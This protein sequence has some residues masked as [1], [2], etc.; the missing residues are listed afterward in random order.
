[1]IHTKLT[2]SQV[3]TMRHEYRAGA[4]FAELGMRYGVHE[5]IAGQA[6][7]GTTWRHVCDPVPYSVT[8]KVRGIKSPNA[9]LTE[10][11]VRT[12]KARLQAGESMCSLARVFG[13]SYSTV[14][15]IKFGK[16]WV[17]VE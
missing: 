10:D 11:D 13:V 14:R 5:R 6:V 2:T 3:M 4:T 7:R 9:K 12:I 8:N 17:H 16:V 15:N 1:M